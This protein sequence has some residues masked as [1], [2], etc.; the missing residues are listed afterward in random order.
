MKGLSPKQNNGDRIGIAFGSF[1]WAPLGQKN[2][3]A[4]LQEAGFQTPLPMLAHNWLPS[5]DYL[6]SIRQQVRDLVEE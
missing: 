2:V 4:T 1:G 5:Q 6:D 3:Y